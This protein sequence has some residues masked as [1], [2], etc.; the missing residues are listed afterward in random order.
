[1]AL[2][3]KWSVNLPS[4]F[5]CSGGG[6]S[7]PQIAYGANCS[8]EEEEEK[9]EELMEKPFKISIAWVKKEEESEE[10]FFPLRE[11]N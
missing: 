8:K 7:G 1:M 5:F 9:E 2:P 10:D 4:L 11:G 3:Q 6:D